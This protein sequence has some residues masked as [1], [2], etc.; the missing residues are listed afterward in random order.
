LHCTGQGLANRQPTS[1]YFGN[2]YLDAFDHW[3]KGLWLTR[4][5][6]PALRGKNSETRPEL[7]PKGNVPGEF[8]G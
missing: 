8:D 2:V 4:I 5:P 6:A 1:Q 3:M 7:V